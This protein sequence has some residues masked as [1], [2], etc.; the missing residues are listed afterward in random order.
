[1]YWAFGGCRFW[2]ATGYAHATAMRGRCVNPALLGM[3]K[4]ISE[5]ALRR[6][7]APIR[8]TEG[9]TWLDAHVRDS[10]WP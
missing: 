5:D 7:L 3:G 10:A 9:I 1:M 8:K 6:A 2:L 4:I